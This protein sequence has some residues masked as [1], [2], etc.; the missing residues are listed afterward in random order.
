MLSLLFGR[1]PAITGAGSQRQ[2]TLVPGAAQLEEMAAL[3]Q[4]STAGLQG[5]IPDSTMLLQDLLSPASVQLPSTTPA[6]L[7]YHLS[8]LSLDDPSQLATITMIVRCVLTSPALWRGQ[9]TAARRTGGTEWPALNFDRSRDVYTAL[10][11]AWLLRINAVK[12]QYGTGWSGRRKLAAFID[13]YVQGLD[14]EV[15]RQLAAAVSDGMTDE[16]HPVVRLIASCACLSALQTVK[17]RRDELYIGGSAIM[18]KAHE[19]VLQCWHSYFKS[20]EDA[21]EDN[22]GRGDVQ[23]DSPAQR[24]WSGSSGGE[25]EIKPHLN[26]SDVPTWLAAQVLPTFPVAELSKGPVAS[27]LQMLGLS[28][29]RVFAAGHIFATLG[30]SIHNTHDGLV[31]TVPSESYSL[32]SSLVKSTNFA[33]LGPISRSIGRL[34][35]AAGTQA[36]TRP[37]D[38]TALLA[39]CTFSTILGRIAS[40]VNRDWGRTFWSDMTEDHQLSPETRNRT[41]PWTMLKALLFSITLMQSSLLEI[42]TPKT[43]DAPT[44]LQ[45]D[46][47]AEAIHVLAK[48]YFVTIRFGNDGFS[49]WKGVWSGLM[50][51]VVQG[52]ETTVERLMGTLEPVRLGERH[53]RLVE[54]S[55]ATFYLNAAEQLMVK[56]REEYT[57]AVVLK[58][59]FPY[60]EDSRYRDTFESAHSVLLAVFA[61]NKRC[62][63]RVVPWYSKL[64][65][66]A[67]PTLMSASQLR[68]AYTTMIRCVSLSDDAL[69]WYCIEQ[70]IS[71]IERTPLSRETASD[72]AQN[73]T[74]DG[75]E[76]KNLPP[77]STPRDY[78]AEAEHP[79]LDEASNLSPLEQTAQRSSRG[80]LLLALIDQTTSVNLVLLTSLL[81]H[82]WR[83]IKLESGPATRFKKK[84]RQDNKPER[85]MSTREAFVNILFQ[86][87][88]EGLD[89]TKRAQGIKYWLDRRDEFEV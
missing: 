34:I 80:P 61:T 26:A 2:L 82:I 64:L 38:T 56:L 5:Q 10:A 86:R 58:C 66:K 37:D 30:N 51:V 6:L 52:P 54:R 55:E 14:D 18:G 79:R 71:A 49:A 62:A 70:L 74:N 69:A 1:S 67:C 87:L 8:T 11:H 33:N 72:V 50:D 60:L 47:A 68:L 85:N 59:V 88:G 31:W 9:A 83:L 76:S 81:D 29:T 21:R 43:E 39:V 48:T 36:R 44:P 41:E 73:G 23:R 89:A 19:V 27:M 3:Q 46:L 57:E 17:L 78:D 77:G 42:V 63:T 13:A 12:S 28:F 32:L 15:D 35:E 40:R 25:F 20:I 24:E 4:Q 22:N 53:D 45:L 65:L 16:V 75:D 7:S 84:E